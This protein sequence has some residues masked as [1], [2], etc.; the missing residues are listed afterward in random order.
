M[1]VV[2]ELYEE[3]SGGEQGMLGVRG[4]HFTQGRKAEL[5]KVK[6]RVCRY[7][8]KSIPTEGTA[9]AKALGCECAWQ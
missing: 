3:K 6:E 9:G 4:C 2:D 7:L 1:L 5:K 8:G